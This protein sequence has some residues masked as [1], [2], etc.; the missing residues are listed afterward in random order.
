M[1]LKNLI[2]FAAVA[3]G[4]AALP[5][6]AVA[7]VA[8]GHVY[9]IDLVDDL[10]YG[11]IVPS[12][13]QPLLIGQKAVIRVR[14]MNTNALDSARGDHPLPW[15]FYP[16]PDLTALGTTLQATLQ[17]KLGLK[18]GGQ[19]V[20][21]E[22]I[23]SVPVAS[24]AAT[25]TDL[26]FEYVVK[27]G[28][29][30]MPAHLMLANGESAGSEIGSDYM[31]LNM[32]YWELK[33][34]DGGRAVFHFYNGGLEPDP[35]PGQPQNKCVSGVGMG[36]FVKT[37]DLDR[38][39]AKP[40]EA[41]GE[42]DIWRQIYRGLTTTTIYGLPTVQVDGQ[43]ESATTLYVWVDKGEGGATVASPL[44]TDGA[45]EVTDPDGTVR[46]VLPVSVPTGVSS[47]AFKLKGVAN[48]RATVKM[49]SSKDLTYDDM[50]T[51]V[52]DW[53]ERVIEVIDPPDPFVSLDL[54]EYPSGTPLPK[55][56]VTLSADYETPSAMLT[57]SL[58]QDPSAELT[59]TLVPD[60][61]DGDLFGDGLLGVSEELE[62][63]PWEG[64]NLEFKFKPGGA[65]TKTLY[66]YAKGTTAK[67]STKGCKFTAET[68]GAPEY[69][70][71]SGKHFCNLI[72]KHMDPVLVKPT[73]E[74]AI[75]DAMAGKNYSLDIAISDAR[76]YMVDAAAGDS[77]YT[78][79]Y[80][81]E[82]PGTE[83]EWDFDDAV[84]LDDADSGESTISVPFD[85]EG[86]C[87]LKLYAVS[88]SGKK[89]AEVAIPVTV[90][91]PKRA[92]A[93][94]D[95]ENGV[96]AEGE[97][98]YVNFHL[99]QKYKS[100]LY[101]FLVPQDD[102]TKAKFETD[103][104]SEVPGAIGYYIGPNDTDTTIPAEVRVID[105]KAIGRFQV[106]MCTTKNYSK[107]KSAGYIGDIF[108]ISA[109]N[110][111][112]VI[113]WV[114]MG[115]RD[116][117]VNG[118]STKTVA[119]GVEKTFRISKLTEPGQLDLDATG[120]DIFRT[121]WKFGTGD[122]EDMDGNPNLSTTLIKHT[123][124][125]PGE[126]EVTVRCQDKDMRKL[127]KWSEE[128]TFTVPVLDI[129]QVKI[130]PV[131]ETKT[132]FED[133]V[134]SDYGFKVILTAPAD[135]ADSTKRLKVK[136]SVTDQST[137]SEASTDLIELSRYE[138]EFSSGVSEG[139]TFHFKSL[140]GTAATAS[141]GHLI[142]AT[143]TNPEID[144][145][146]KT[147]DPGDVEVYIQNRAP[148]ILNPAEKL[149]KDG[150]PISTVTTIGGENSLAW[151]L[152]DVKA[153]W[154]GMTV[155]W[156]TSEGTRTVY[157]QGDP[158][159]DD[160]MSGTHTFRFSS[161]GEKTITVTATD[162]DG[163]SDSRTFYYTIKP[164]KTLKLIPHGPTGGKGTKLSTKYG[165]ASGLGEG[166]VYAKNVS[167]VEGFEA[168]YNCGLDKVWTLYAYGYKVGDVSG[169]VTTEPTRENRIDANGDLNDAGGYAYADDAKDSF[170]YTWIEIVAG[171]SGGFTDRYLNDAISPEKSWEKSVGND[172]QLP[173]DADED[174]TYGVTIAEAVFSKEY[175][176]SDNM[177]DINQDG[178]PDLIVSKYAKLG[179]VENGKVV[180]DD[181][182]RITDA[183][184]GN[185]DEDF[186]P[187]TEQ[188]R[189]ATLI[190]GLKETWVQAGKPFS[191]RFEIR[192]YH[193]G[194]NDAF[195]AVLTDGTRNLVAIS[196]VK[197]E[198]VYE[199][200]GKYDPEKCTISFLEY[201][202]WKEYE[203]AN[204]GA[205]EKDWSP[206]RPTDPTLADTD[207]DGLPD[208]Y[209]YYFWYRT[210]V[211]Y[212][213][214]ETVNGAAVTNH[215]YLHG[216][217]YDPTN[218][219]KGVLIRTEE[220]RGLYDPLVAADPTTVNERD[221]DNDG[222]PDLLE[223][224]LGTNPFHWDTDG[225]G[226]PDGYEV[227]HAADL[228]LDPLVASSD[229]SQLD[230]E[231]ND[232][233]DWM[234]IA[235]YP[236]KRT[237]IGTLTKDG[238][239]D[240]WHFDRML[241]TTTNG[242]ATVN[243][244]N[245]LRG[246]SVVDDAVTNGWLVCTLDGRTNVTTVAEV[247]TV[248]AGGVIRLAT[249]LLPTECW[250]QR[251]SDVKEKRERK[252]QQV[253]YK[254]LPTY[255]GRGTALGKA[256]EKIEITLQHFAFKGTDGKP[257]KMM[258]TTNPPPFRA[259][260]AWVYGRDWKEAEN[261]NP[262][263]YGAPW[264]DSKGKLDRV[265]GT[266]RKPHY[267]HG[268]QANVSAKLE[269]CVAP[270]D[271]LKGSADDLSV[272]HHHV[273][274]E[275]E[276]D[277]RT[278]WGSGPRTRQY[279]A[280]DE[281]LMTGFFRYSTDV[282]ATELAPTPQTP[283]TAI[284]AKYSTN[285]AD[286]DSDKDGLPDGWEAYLM[287][288]PKINRRLSP[289]IQ[290]GENNQGG[291]LGALSTYSPLVP[292]TGDDRDIETLKY[293]GEKYFFAFSSDGLNWWE[294]Y[295]GVA[296]SAAYAHC[297]TIAE[298]YT[299]KMKKWRNKKWP[300]DPWACDTDGDG[301][302]DG[303]EYA[304]PFLY[305][306][307]GTAGGGLNPLSWDTDGDGLPDPWE[308]EFAGTYTAGKESTT[309]SVVQ[310][311]DGTATTNRV[312]STEGGGWNND[313]MDGTVSDASLDYDHDGLLNWQEYM[314]GSVRA[315]R[316]DDSCSTWGYHQYGT[317]QNMLY[318]F[319]DDVANLTFPVAPAYHDPLDEHDW[320]NFWSRLLIDGRNPL[321]N[322][323]IGGTQFDAAAAFFSCC[324]HSW[325]STAYNKW[326][327]F[328]DGVDHDLKYPSVGYCRFV[329]M[330]HRAVQFNRYTIKYWDDGVPPDDPII[331]AGGQS[332][333]GR[334]QMDSMYV[335]PLKYISCDPRKPDSDH[336]GMDDYYEIY[337]GLNPLLGASAQPDMGDMPCDLVF[338]AYNPGGATSWWGFQPGT[339]IF[340]AELNFW[341]NPDAPQLRQ[342]W[343]KGSLYDF[344]VYPWLAGLQGADPD[345]DNIRN[346]EEAIMPGLQAQSTWHHTDPSA[347]WMTDST[348]GNSLTRRYYRMPTT[349]PGDQIYTQIWDPEFVPLFWS[350]LNENGIKDDFEIFDLRDFPYLTWIPANPPAFTPA[351]IIF[352]GVDL[353]RWGLARQLDWLGFPMS[354]QIVQ[355][356]F[357]FEEDEGYDSDHDYL[358]DYTEAQA[359]S[360]Q[361]SDPQDTDDPRRRQ[362]MYLDG[363]TSFLQTPI[364]TAEPPPAQQMS[365]RFSMIDMPFL[366][367]TVECWVKPDADGL[368][369]PDGKPNQNLQA[370][371]ERAISVGSS[372]AGD[373]RT[374]RKNF[375]LGVQGGKWYTKYDSSGTDLALPV[376]VFGPAATTNWTHL[377]ATYDGEALR[378]FVNGNLYRSVSS[379]VQPEHGTSLLAISPFGTLQ[380]TQPADHISLLVGADAVTDAAL[381][382]D[383][384][385]RYPNPM[386]TP[387]VVGMD[388][389][390]L[391]KGYVD[392]VRV[393]DG[394][395]EQ[396]EIL[397]DYRKRYT[398]EDA[399]ANRDVIFSSLC[400]GMTRE[401]SSPGK[402]PAELKYHFTFDHLP[403]ATQTGWVEKAPSGFSTDA[404]YDDA[405]A[406]MT[407]PLGWYSPWVVC[408]PNSSVYSDRAWTPWVINTVYHL[409]YYDGS[410]GDS[411]YWSRYLAGNQSA[412]AAGISEFSFPLVAETSSRRVNVTFGGDDGSS[413]GLPTY[414]NNAMEGGDDLLKQKLAFTWRHRYSMGMDMMPMGNAYPRRISDTEGGMWDEQGPADAWAETGADVNGDGIPE[415]WLTY[416]RIHYGSN[417]K[418]RE[419]IT[420]TT[421]INYNGVLMPA[422]QAYQRDLAKGM[423]PDT[424]YYPEY[425]NRADSDHNGLPDWWEENWS[426][427]NTSSFDDPDHD[428]LSNFQEWK[429]S[430][431]EANGF[432]T[433]RGFP[434]LNPTRAYSDTEQTE[435]DYFLRTFLSPWTGFYFGEIVGD[436]D[437]MEDDNEDLMGTDRNVYDPY[438]DKDEDG[439][440]AWSEMRFS[441]FK[442]TRAAKFLSHMNDTEEVA[443]FPIPVIHAMLRYNGTKALAVSNVSIVVEA[444]SGN[445]LQK[446]PTA[447]YA[448]VPGT[449][450]ERILYLGGYEN[451]VVHGTLTPGFVRGGRDNVWLQTAFIQPNEKWAW[452]I[453][454]TPHS[455]T[456]AEM[457]AAYL[458]ARESFKIAS[459]DFQ[460]TDMF[461]TDSID[462][463][464]VS[465]LQISIDEQTQRGYLNWFHERIGT[466]DLTTGDFTLDLA[467]VKDYYVP[468]TG[469]NF[470]Q[471]LF[472]IKY[473]TQ[474]PTMQTKALG[475]SLA[476]PDEGHLVEGRTAFVA[477]MDIDG[478]GF[479]PNK[480]PVGFVKDVDVSWD[481]VPEI[482][483]EMTDESPAEKGLRFAY[484]DLG[485]D[486]VR[487]VRTSINGEEVLGEEPVRRRIVFS[488]ETASVPRNT[489]YEGDLV[490]SGKFGLDW[491]SLR[492]D[493][494]AMDG[495]QLRDVT[496]VG[497]VI[498]RGS[499]SVLHI[500]PADVLG[501]FTVTFPATPVKPA[502]AEPTVSAS[503]IV[504]TVRPTFRWTGTDDNKAFMLQIA[505]AAGT[506][507][508]S[509]DMQVLPARDTLSRYAFTA[510]VFIG[511]NVLGAAVDSWALNNH[512]NYQWRVAMFNA[513]YSSP[514]DAAWSDWAQ[515]RTEVA[516]G[517]DFS[518]DSGTGRVTVRYFG[519]ATNGLDAVVVRLY[520]TAD[521]TGVPAAQTRLY[522]V[523]GTAQDLTNTVY[524]VR[525]AGL[526]S[527]DYYAMA[528][529]D[530][531]GNMTRD[532][533]ETWGYANQVG[534]GLQ[535]IYTP[536]AL[537]VDAKS[538]EVN[539]VTVFMEDTDLNADRVLDCLQEDEAKYFAAVAAG[540]SGGDTTDV[541]GDGLT[542][543]EESGDTYTKP[544]KWDT[545]GDRMPDGWEARFADLDPLFDD[546][547]TTADGDVMA[548]ETEDGVRVRDKSGST[549]LLLA[550]SNVTYRV[551][552]L[553][554]NEHLY[555][556]YDYQTVI[557]EGTNATTVSY[558][559]IGTNL[560]GTA[561]TFQIDR[562][563]PVTV[564]YVHA[565]VYDRYGYSLKTAIPQDGAIHTKPFTALDKYMIVR[566]LAAMG[567]A[568]ED[569]MNL[570]RTPGAQWKDFT[571]RPMDA[572]N[573]RDGML[574]GWELYVMFGT[575]G[576]GFVTNGVGQV[577]RATSIDQV[578]ISPWKFGDRALDL[579]GDGLANVDEN[580][581]GNDPS[582]PW[583]P[584]SVYE[585]L[586]ADGVIP[587]DTEKF[588]DKVRRFGIGESEL[589]TD[590]DIDLISNGQEMW[591]YYIDYANK[592][593]LLADI[594]PKNAWSDG[595]TPDYFRTFKT[596]GGTVD[597]LGAAWNG[598][599]FIEPSARE[600]LG[601]TDLDRAGTR[602]LYHSGW[603]VWSIVRSSLKA[604]EEQAEAGISEELSVAIKYTYVVY[605][606]QGFEGSTE[607]DLVD[608]HVNTL[609]HEG[610]R[611]LGEVVAGHGGL[612]AMKRT[613]REKAADSLDVDGFDIP[614]PTINFTFK[615]AGNNQRDVIIDAYQVSSSYPEYGEQLTASWSAQPAF[616]AGVGYYRAKTTGK[617]TLK[618]GKTRFVAYI[619]VDGDGKFSAA[620]TWGTATAE[621]GYLG[622]DVEI[623]LGEANAAAYPVI[624]LTEGSNTVS[625]IAL[626]RSAINGKP[627]Y[628]DAVGAFIVQ[629]PNN[630]GREALCPQDYVMSGHVGIDKT[631][632]SL[633]NVG[634]V[635]SVTY[636][637]LRLT[638]DEIPL[639]SITNLNHYV[640]IGTNGV[641]N[642]VDQAVNEEVTVRYSLTRDIV[643]AIAVAGNTA[644]DV[645]LSFTVPTDTA[646]SRFW[647]SVT[648]ETTGAAAIYGG[649]DGLVLTGMRDGVVVLDS[650][651]ME[652]N[653]VSVTTGRV[654]FAV[655]LGNDK[656]GRPASFAGAPTATMYVNA[657]RVY[658]GEIAVRVAHPTAGI[659]DGI[660]VAAYD[661]ADL[662]NPVAFTNGNAAGVVT[663]K[664]LRAGVEYYVA[665]WYVKNAGDGRADASERRPY[666]TWGYLTVLGEAANG[667]DAK[668]A[669]AELAASVTNLVFLQDTDW[670]DNNVIDRVENFSSKDGTYVKSVTPTYGL[671]INGLRSSLFSDADEG[672]V[673]AYALVDFPCVATT[674]GLGET[675]WYVIYD[676]G[677]ET[678]KNRTTNGIRKG[679]P[680]SEL[681]T[682][683]S[684]Y[685]YDEGDSNPTA[686]ALGRE[687]AVSGDAKV[688]QAATKSIVLV[689]AQVYAKFGFNPNTANGLI[690][691]DAWVNT[692]A[693]DSTDK[694]YVVNYLRNVLRVA[695]AADFSL[696]DAKN[697]TYPD[698]DF[699]A[700]GRG[701]GIPD[702]WELYVM[703]GTN[704][705]ADLTANDLTNA[706]D[707]IHS[708]WNY[709][710]RHS[711]LDGDELDQLHEYDG[712]QEP[713]DPWNAYSLYENLAKKG[714]LLPGTPKFTDAVAR[715][716]DLTVDTIHD[717]D[718]L[719]L[720]DNISEM[721]AY[722]RDPTALADL[723]VTN[724]WSNG[725]TN[726]YF[727]VAGSKYLGELFNG[728]EFIEPDYRDRLGM[729][730]GGL[731]R[732]GTR[733]CDGTGWDYWSVVRN[734]VSGKVDIED[735][736]SA[737]KLDIIVKYLQ[738][739][740]MNSFEGSTLKEAQD[741]LKQNDDKYA[742]W[743]KAT[744]ISVDELSDYLGGYAYMMA[745]IEEET[746]DEVEYPAPA[747]NL[748]LKYAG[749][750]NRNVTVIA[751]QTTPTYPE[752]GEQL[753]ARWDVNPTFN[754]GVA[755]V[756]LRD[757]SAGSLKQGPA[758]FVAYID[759]D[760]DG[761]LSA[762]DTFGTATVTVGYLGVDV[763]I[764]LGDVNAA[765][766]IIDLSSVPNELN[767][768]A[769]VRVAVNGIVQ[770]RPRG[771]WYRYIDNN[772][773]RGV[774]YPFDFVTDEFIGI[775]RDLAK[776]DFGGRDVLSVTYAVLAGERPF[777]H[778]D[779]IGGTNGTG[780]CLGAFTV[781]YSAKR[782]QATALALASSL[783]NN[784]TLSF[785][786][787]ENCRSVT[788]F[789]VKANDEVYGG[790]RGFLLPPGADGTVVIDLAAFGIPVKVGED[791]TFAVALGND[792]FGYPAADE[793]FCPDATFKVNAAPARKG[794]IVAV[795]AHPTASF[796]DG[797]TVAVYEKADLANP[798]KVVTNKAADAALTIDG[799]RE[800]AEYYI[801]AWYVK[802]AEDGRGSAAERKPYDT[803]GYLTMLGE[804]E[805]GFDAK[806]VK[807][808][809]PANRMVDVPMTTNLVFLQDTDWNDNGVLDREEDFKAINGAVRENEADPLGD[810][811]LDEIPDPLD[812]DPVIPAD[813]SDG[814]DD[815]AYL[816]RGDMMACADVPAWFVWVGTGRD[817]AV[818]Y[819][820]MDINGEGVKLRDSDIP[821]QT[822]AVDLEWL[823]TTYDYGSFVGLGK[824]VAPT[825]GK[826]LSVEP[827]FARLVHAQVYAQFGYETGCATEA[828]HPHTKAFTQFDKFLVVRYLEA[829][830]VPDIDELTLLLDPANAVWNLYKLNVGD[831][832]FDDIADG[833][834]LYTMFG[835]TGLKAF[836]GA[837]LGTLAEAKISPFN[838]A[839]GMLVAPG[840]GSQ[841]KLVEEFDGGYYP[842]DP[843]AVDTDRDQVIDY[844]AYQY[845]LKGED[846]WKD[847]DGDGL[848]NYAEYLISE[849]FQ[850]AKLNPDKNH[851][852]EGIHD[853]FRKLGELYLGEIFTDHDQMTDTWEDL[854]DV[855]VVSRG[856]Y[857]PDEDY[858]NDGWSNY[859]E[860]RAGTDPSTD[861]KLGVDGYT[862]NEYPIP[863]IEAKVVY[864]GQD[865]NLG[866]IVFKAWN[867]ADDPQMTSV[868]DAIWTIGNGKAKESGDTAGAGA[869]STET[870]STVED[871]VKYVG[872]RPN[873]VQRYA[874]GGG[875]VVPGT[876][877]VSLYDPDFVNQSSSNATE[878]ADARWYVDVTDKNGVLY[879]YL[880]KSVGTVDYDT[881]VMT[882]DCSQL[883][884]YATARR[885]SSDA[886]PKK[887]IVD[888]ATS[889]GSGGDSYFTIL[890]DNA[891]LR[892]NWQ[893]QLVGITPNGTYTLGDADAVT[894]ENKSHGHVREGLNTFICFADEDGDGEYTPG[895]LFGVVRGVDVGWQ[896]AKFTVELTEVNPITTRIDLWADQGDRAT[897]I[898]DINAAMLN[899]R[900]L[901]YHRDGSNIVDMTSL[902]LFLSNRVVKADNLD[903]N[904]TAH[905]RVVRYG[906]DDMYCY[907]AGIY[908][909]GLGVGFDQQVVLDKTFDPAGRKF[910]TEQDF[911][912]PDQFDIDWGTMTWEGIKNTDYQNNGIVSWT[913]GE[914]LG[915]GTSG[916]LGSGCGVTNMTY[917]VVIG[918][919]AKDFRGSTDTN[920]HVRALATVVTRRFEKT[921]TRP[922][923]DATH[924]TFYCAQPTFKWSMKGEDEWASEFGSTYTAFRL[925]IVDDANTSDVVYD[926]GIVRAP[927]QD[928]DGNFVWTAPVYA[929]SQTPQ[930]N[931]FAPLKTYKWHVTMYNAK[932][933]SDFWSSATGIK[934]TYGE[935]TMDVNR[936]QE[937]ND[938]EYSSIDVAV[939]Y[940]GPS[941]VLEKH[942]DL[943]ELKGKVR[944][945]AFTT[946]DFSGEP[947]AEV[948]A[949]SEVAN[950]T[951]AFPNAKLVGLPV[952]GTYYVRAY[953]DM[954][955][956]F[957]KDD[958]ES[959]GRANEFVAL[960]ADDRTVQIVGLFIEDADTDRD[961][962]PDA[963]EYA[964]AGWSREFD[965]CKNDLNAKPKEGGVIVVTDNL[966]AA[967][968]GK[969][970]TAGLSTGLPGVSLTTL[971]NV[972]YAK[973]LLGIDGNVNKTTFEA[974]REAVEGKVAKD[975]LR[976]TSLTM[977]GDKVI[978]TV[979]A[980]VSYE[981]AGLPLDKIYDLTQFGSVKVKIYKKDTLLDAAWQFVK[982]VEKTF[983][984]GEE[985]VEIQTP[986][987]DF[988]SGFYKVEIV[989]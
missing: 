432:G 507:V 389:R 972:D 607:Q 175:L 987:V 852:S 662:A 271:P 123:F 279:N 586:V 66:L 359:R 847:F 566:Y 937:V 826:V 557:G 335:Y 954:N 169:A 552:N 191:A 762:A 886:S 2:A 519:P 372:N 366:Y 650:D 401:P 416:A 590:W 158:G 625:T 515:F 813:G 505:D 559:G 642:V 258:A 588:D 577:V 866:S 212:F 167:S 906:I 897:T 380:A 229:N 610:E 90:A 703:F 370:I 305:G 64:D 926:S 865:V 584:Y 491:S 728:A 935:F 889:D 364:L 238:R 626:V 816:R 675:V 275:Y 30:S 802:D 425:V 778:L 253:M 114:S 530:R 161:A 369:G 730:E 311:D 686:L 528:F 794:A 381:V 618:Q 832:D 747:V 129:P 887:L 621:V 757:A 224:E 684:T 924:T 781:P 79:H 80:K 194:L 127:G 429:I 348:Y 945:Q 257:M 616:D 923:V 929:G 235:P 76:K 583:N 653:S 512:S 321:F 277:P 771:V 337:H 748:T 494:L 536:F 363:K 546:A 447:R 268:F 774:L 1:K 875:S 208:G 532:R 534:L 391:Y 408:G 225:D 454:G 163:E 763:E 89:S 298:R 878:A 799:L 165:T 139:P 782:D 24:P 509:N 564:A 106:F 259:Y 302:F 103:I 765:L 397:A 246:A 137:G 438:S 240:Y 594:D 922:T 474:L 585:S 188:S 437:F 843:W 640:Y 979:D 462:G 745:F 907:M 827:G 732:A 220:I 7:D 941:K 96:Y 430:E 604:Q 326:Y 859:A 901:R 424:K 687:T 102:D 812:D 328:A 511:T 983:S 251:L 833:W 216:E 150:N 122:W 717:D 484:G 615:Y 808:V 916:P 772:V 500:A 810:F 895:E 237:V 278:A 406:I 544:Q 260:T 521:F 440:T 518:T 666:D 206:E 317:V 502:C 331:G 322:P 741:Y 960:T 891:Y 663:L 303:A 496:E 575:N 334:V 571:L 443:D 179:I 353:N 252:P 439:W 499:G 473:K 619:D 262:G 885:N 178:L 455:G 387:P 375:L 547:A 561:A 472:R 104:S 617:G 355:W 652:R 736:T 293:D 634:E 962:L 740:T 164:S 92:M 986:G 713:T 716:F 661:R 199:V 174:G 580:C 899:D 840:A 497:Y 501:R 39:Y 953:I 244:T 85:I 971:Q 527:G 968:N 524:T 72:V 892:I 912:G 409:P 384:V 811:D 489:V 723:S 254:G 385:L 786:I 135:I 141:S 59:V 325:D 698:A 918:D 383:R 644:D 4:V 702:G 270:G 718:D 733:E 651:W 829:I 34:A 764:A 516:D 985:T 373:M 133:Q 231:R 209:E 739:S 56:T 475:V 221:T 658:D 565:Q 679:T 806:A 975:T 446:A 649:E 731:V 543:D 78:V 940:T 125:S 290:A 562:I 14:L 3:L 631:L 168:V 646:N 844:Y 215:V 563:E 390:S 759:A 790:D 769:I 789:W 498:T 939:K 160:V 574:D 329:N 752:F 880:S 881:G 570:N 306:S 795:V 665:A 365:A 695:D 427:R 573:D 861:T 292:Y 226:L 620:D 612:E 187:T 768:V 351:I 378:L 309:E 656:F 423:L 715:K 46:L 830:G 685:W 248:T 900:T 318:G 232:D 261:I 970:L 805:S 189:F 894:A 449:S 854:Y 294:E 595:T 576:C 848:S 154:T 855:S 13:S 877:K 549:Y 637:V 751:Y 49:S 396:S 242:L 677:R 766:P 184:V 197:P 342:Q 37:V 721:V 784:A 156:E 522:D 218:P 506:V 15:K 456:Y 680:L 249:D 198:R 467:K 664:G 712:G 91:A 689:H 431:D 333:I 22:F 69:D 568:D 868:P 16:T 422:W 841:L 336:D 269:I 541:D 950:A 138:V 608:F 959:W 973:L 976:I 798:V 775:D 142:T 655:V 964:Y 371:V 358:S 276:Y 393:W 403:G 74:D 433:V 357:S 800:G 539:T 31:L 109:T 299:E 388:Y 876:V 681:K 767:G 291:P 77:A 414:F 804:S 42:P 45:F 540:S 603:D 62:G 871:H 911:L 683:Y 531:N 21:A 743:N 219:H 63:T 694:Q 434:E 969:T 245:D 285:P 247:K 450:L 693:F 623:A 624:S 614:E 883:T 727:R 825:S 947:V 217:R 645:K 558:C 711:D 281:F 630:A 130:V 386:Q 915:T 181:L 162:K 669:K 537:H 520:R 729:R 195:A 932:F 853:Y 53:V 587:A 672:D 779:L 23:E 458:A 453:D 131:Q 967:L 523:A 332:F 98:A 204:P 846:S 714:L 542:A 526:A 60:L 486:T 83:G 819:V 124:F 589:D 956:N 11:G 451:R 392:E 822:E 5:R 754:A 128:F 982:E 776:L 323:S 555:T 176:W 354:G 50:G 836:T 503:P 490:S 190:P 463:A 839:D 126:H 814:S 32:N 151:S 41:E 933:R 230:G 239:V 697:N 134:G 324:K 404:K 710:D 872:R 742:K 850:V 862:K 330:Q 48:G 984:K 873:G 791:N 445:N 469:V 750:E 834:E 485:D 952:G 319:P 788:K 308:L 917:L 705:I 436:H 777:S 140:D 71:E 903:L 601:I 572:D 921:R 171:E 468:A 196:G 548:F 136:L 673:M 874:L 966:M 157:K 657:G 851:T 746:K 222:L 148:S 65:L 394:A 57:I 18:L 597:Y 286:A 413:T 719:D 893:A 738:I 820:L 75:T 146:G 58:S 835:K 554:T 567:L 870:A 376:E 360:R 720:I 480:D 773:D 121:Q 180:G 33:N 255:M 682:L 101:A 902:A 256:P 435:V 304:A 382:F 338:E 73:K 426:I 961:W 823:A 25:Y 460:W 347:L 466:I 930:G 362:A 417:L 87:T 419:V 785:R 55:N 858:D 111:V 289:F 407:R 477:Y 182:A 227:M 722:Y 635:E 115:G 632:S 545:D 957:K 654:S 934:K 553:V 159:W 94:L 622:V 514:A 977:T 250:L 690:G 942:T 272:I 263:T 320:D 374:I 701:D 202:A 54:Q 228:G 611:S 550:P 400:A 842:T 411:M 492:G 310:N 108:T 602:D 749:T 313:G 172:I 95:R 943:G 367:Y 448:V 205:T 405:R 84:Y 107:T 185:V 756:E 266:V 284:W 793:D 704:A 535:A 273:Y 264:Y 913:T 884:G 706:A 753:S 797:V 936:Q 287:S 867:D 737:E 838:T 9:S 38:N 428:G 815:E 296:S 949:V 120:D 904:K 863:V 265:R 402:L 147:W 315:W 592:S 300:T 629:F 670:N 725:V 155:T 457:Y 377:A 593:T 724:A 700:G 86:E 213:Q 339:A 605:G 692:K 99:T 343:S 533:W 659:A 203:A 948:C 606:E 418:P 17:P 8:Q 919:G 211:G 965:A 599:E 699:V 707:R 896:G 223:F 676:L 327:Y 726:D 243:T 144:S 989:Q 352:N 529:I 186:L 787:D 647:L 207:D 613:I 340:N 349:T 633:A 525:F 628:N 483:I 688:T 344:T 869:P 395:R 452:E 792:R 735:L 910:L 914:P 44:K 770:E 888:K 143:V 415:W 828:G 909:G 27:S 898:D 582:D 28:D 241:L 678:T 12:E 280:Y 598:A 905:I 283:L 780:R 824:T 43:A 200:G 831:S 958:W 67:F 210:H 538:A 399:L 471:C 755:S 627:L 758:R 356:M 908:K 52:E 581:D 638:P 668:A 183:N 421:V 47:V 801:A 925:Q 963:W 470:E 493:I 40:A 849:V 118:G 803:W 341:L 112:P 81:V 10:K 708:P 170:L 931:V 119:Q 818:R 481:N 177:G 667:F 6:A 346:R 420:R 487:I 817:D 465:C 88:P 36:L 517:N 234:A 20:Y 379:K 734:M 110:V 442:M 596:N 368:V 398:R 361:A 508:W 193:D 307:S 116:I 857:D 350:D 643:K 807:A 26:Y 837:N 978:L 97:T 316:Y 946:A 105:G 233:K 821:L 845:H 691:E 412:T 879:D 464:R 479:T 478:D 459:D 761:K 569:V 882:L 274:Q 980:D 600:L 149:D 981:I 345:G 70:S 920:T 709:A 760:G 441:T 591:S 551:G 671:K 132:Y 560:T 166:R 951:D 955:G 510:P 641:S 744:G 461:A 282:V 117:K 288:G 974:I 482:V 495:L 314:T 145:E 93:T 856:Q 476:E 809:D 609:G 301:L 153:D 579:D 173:K 410:T 488:R 556:C 201:L 29:L 639:L 927:K 578:E 938:H 988:T 100:E 236:M 783:T 648:N 504:T 796:A 636:E 864:N 68:T 51:L 860:F 297:P 674:N 214:V 696:V 192:G 267:V 35:V 890:R 152:K 660:T 444:Y 928:A 312:T 61:A 82:A 19:P 513:K 113:N 944:V 295:A